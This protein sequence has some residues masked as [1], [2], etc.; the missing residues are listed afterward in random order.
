MA[1]S[2]AGA[3]LTV[4]FTAGLQV[5]DSFII[6][7]VKLANPDNWTAPADGGAVVAQPSV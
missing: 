3:I 6:G 2:W 4:V 7:A 1:F 5:F